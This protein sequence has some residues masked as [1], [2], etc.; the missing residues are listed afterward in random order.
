MSTGTPYQIDTTTGFSKRF[1]TLNFKG[2][3]FEIAPDGGIIINAASDRVWIYGD[4]MYGPLH[5]LPMDA[6]LSPNPGM[7]NTRPSA[8][9]QGNPLSLVGGKNA[10]AYALQLK[11]GSLENL[12]LQHETNNAQGTRVSFGAETTALLTEGGS[13]GGW[14]HRAIA[15]SFSLSA[16]TG[17]LPTGQYDPLLV[18]GH[19]PISVVASNTCT[20]DTFGSTGGLFGKAPSNNA[21]LSVVC[22]VAV[23][24]NVNFGFQD[25]TLDATSNPGTHITGATYVGWYFTHSGPWYKIVDYNSATN[26][27]KIFPGMAANPAGK[28]C[29]LAPYTVAIGAEQYL[30][31]GGAIIGVAR[32]EGNNL[33]RGTGVIGIGDPAVLEAIEPEPFTGRSPFDIETEGQQHNHLVAGTVGGLFQGGAA[34]DGL[35]VVGGYAF[36]SSTQ[37]YDEPIPHRFGDAVFAIAQ[38]EDYRVVATDSGVA[39]SSVVI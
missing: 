21:L 14:G 8:V 33:G 32:S 18:R 30:G 38:G 25:I 34:S 37:Q 20:L 7:D 24:P 29:Y 12:K 27:I 16:A 2:G 4:R 31:S 39:A 5:I 28:V 3:T 22:T 35:Q 36:R 26:T 9:F 23:A 13:F 15:R 1:E 11:G 19:Q 10:A 17:T 6:A